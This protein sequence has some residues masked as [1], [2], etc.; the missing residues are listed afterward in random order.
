MPVRYI[1]ASIIENDRTILRALQDISEYAPRDDELSTTMLS[2]SEAALVQAE[3]ET[4]RLRLAYEAARDR[5]T[6][7]GLA[8]H[9][10]ILR[11]KAEVIAQ[12]GADSQAV[13]AMGLKRK[14][15]RKR[16]VRRRK[17]ASA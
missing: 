12:F 5:E 15:E 17:A 3:I 9:N 13:H 8:F 16:P 11:A 4:A 14:S 1:A 2:A 7:A 10:N 6:E